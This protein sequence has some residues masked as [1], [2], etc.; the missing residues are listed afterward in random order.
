LNFLLGAQVQTA[1]RYV[2]SGRLYDAA[3][4]ALALLS[5]NDEL[6][7]GTQEIRL[8]AFGKLIRDM[9][10][11]FPLSLRDVQGFLLQER[12]PDRALMARRPGLVYT[13]Q[14]YTLS[15]FSDAEWRS[16]ER[17]RYLQALQQDVTA[18]QQAMRPGDPGSSS[19]PPQ[20]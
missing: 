15:Q 10:P 2:V 5:F 12:F 8:Q 1:G 14:S 19:A 20:P 4:Q 9:K 7:A 11:S 16:A 3:G 6:A 13:S 18:A 17:D